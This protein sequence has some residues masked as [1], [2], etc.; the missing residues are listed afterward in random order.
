MMHFLRNPEYG[1]DYAPGYVFFSY[2]TTSL[3][4]AGI[5]LFS[6]FESK[7]PISHC[8]IVTGQRECIEAAQ[9]GGVQKADFFEKYLRRQDTV[10]FLMKP[11]GL[12][13]DIA[14][15]M[16]EE[17]EQHIGK[18]YAIKGVIGSAL[19]NTLGFISWGWFRKKR[20]PFNSKKNFFCSELV[21]TG[22]MAEEAYPE[23]PGCLVYHPTNIYPATLFNDNDIFVPWNDNQAQKRKAQGRNVIE[24]TPDF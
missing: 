14:E 17:V 24:V 21:A 6:R 2:T 10:V 3:I 20:N 11:H 13:P 8:G 23:R 15:A 19:W 9:P 12:T 22:L 16:K 5:A 4:S 18:G 1:K 7:I